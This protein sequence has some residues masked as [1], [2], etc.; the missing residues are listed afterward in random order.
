MGCCHSSNAKASVPTALEGTAREENASISP[1]LPRDPATGT[2]AAGRTVHADPAHHVVQQE[3]YHTGTAATEAAA[4]PTSP[5]SHAAHDAVVIEEHV[6]EEEKIIQWYE[7]RET[8]QGMYF[9]CHTSLLDTIEFEDKVDVHTEFFSKH[10]N[11]PK[12][13]EEFIAIRL[14]P[15]MLEKQRDITRISSYRWENVKGLGAKNVFSIPSNFMWFV[16]AL[17]ENRQIGWI[18]FIANIAVNVPVGDTLKY[19]GGL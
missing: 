17:K 3:Q 14:S 1:G 10:R 5:A 12:G 11:C 6:S 13:T 4:G 7:G 2:T 18:D 8:R 15:E 16:E 19:M 9:I